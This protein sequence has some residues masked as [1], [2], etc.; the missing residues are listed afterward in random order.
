MQSRER[1][2][3]EE[4]SRKS[5]QEK[6]ELRRR[7]N[8]YGRSSA[9]RSFRKPR[10]PEPPPGMTLGVAIGAVNAKAAEHGFHHT[11][12]RAK[13]AGKGGK[14]KGK[15]KSKRKHP[16]NRTSMVRFV[17]RDT[18]DFG[19]DLDLDLDD[20]VSDSDGD[21]DGVKGSRSSRGP[22]T[23]ETKRRRAHSNRRARGGSVAA[24]SR[25]E[26]L[27]QP[28]ER[29]RARMRDGMTAHVGDTWSRSGGPL[30]HA[31]AHCTPGV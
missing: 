28:H 2:Q 3:E 19:Y 15:G 20:G 24:A 11:A 8:K 9:R 26:N 27:K 13:T 18:D 21:C 23:D 7:S 12:P 22:D 1:Q 4:A 30:P 17:V 25:G 14:G 31:N 6:E 10:S 5:R 16:F 29:W